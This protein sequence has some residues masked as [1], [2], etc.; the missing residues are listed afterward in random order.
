MRA[1]AGLRTVDWRRLAAYIAA[2]L[3]AT[4]LR[5]LLGETELIPGGAAAAGLD[6]ATST[7]AIVFGL[8]AWARF[9]VMKD[10]R[11]QLLGSGVLAFGFLH[12]YAGI[13]GILG[14]GSF[15]ATPSAD[16]L[17]VISDGA[18][19]ALVSSVAM[20]AM[21]R[22]LRGGLVRSVTLVLVLC[23]L[24]A[25]L[26]RQPDA[27][28]VPASTVLDSAMVVM[29][30]LAVYGA[31][32]GSSWRKTRMHHMLTVGMVFLA[33]AEVPLPGA[34]EGIDHGEVSVYSIYLVLAVG[35]LF[36][37]GVSQIVA[38]F[39]YVQVANRRLE[40]ANRDLVA[41][42][43]RAE[44]A[45]RARGVFLGLIGHELRTPLNAIS[46]FAQLLAMDRAL[47]PEQHHRALMV[48]D[49]ARRLAGR[50]DDVLALTSA[51]SSS[52]A[53]GDAGISAPALLEPVARAA[54]SRAT[55]AGLRFEYRFEPAR[56]A[57]RDESLARVLAHLLDNAFRFT[58]RGRVTVSGCPDG[59]GYRLVVTDTGPGVPAA[60]RDRLFAPFTQAENGTTRH[61]GG[62]G[63][64]L[65]V[66]ATLVEAMKGT[67]RL[68]A[69]GPGG[70][71]FVVRVPL[72][73]EEAS[74]SLVQAGPG[75]IA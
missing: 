13:V 69:T 31:V 43:N 59:D 4:T 57:T 27:V 56:L 61:H 3:L 16:S 68:E 32:I 47:T 21:L 55:A 9:A 60:V 50:V 37:G 45:S 62:L 70:S 28:T 11:Y 71:T 52:Q 51:G 36:Q 64:G 33:A 75:G 53:P 30:V 20:S 66:A 73:S 41:A 54:A 63:L 49:G 34:L 42:A 35:C 40:V 58:E 6:A 44:A 17:D 7:L 72:A 25:A 10:L 65:A 48:D 46:G 38:D 26:A 24:T 15:Q 5:Q 29:G 2:G 74:R 39:R 67:I 8:V 14:P 1:I 22:R 18:N 19:L 23:G 12:F